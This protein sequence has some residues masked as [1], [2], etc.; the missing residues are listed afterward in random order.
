MSPSN[1]H[2]SPEQ[3]LA[4]FVDPFLGLFIATLCAVLLTVSSAAMSM[5]ST[6]VEGSS[7]PANSITV[8]MKVG[9]ER[10]LS[11]RSPVGQ[12]IR[13]R[14]EIHAREY[15]DQL[16]SSANGA[17]ITVYLCPD[18]VV[19]WHEVTRVVQSIESSSRQIV[20]ARE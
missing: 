8:V 19:A 4:I 12:N 5:K 9:P 3:G 15:L 20:M 16:S 13:L 11:V 7:M 2:F 18:G 14:D 17:G 1:D 6:P 10:N